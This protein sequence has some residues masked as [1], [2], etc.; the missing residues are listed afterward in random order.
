MHKSD[1]QR[2]N[3]FVSGCNASQLCCEPQEA[4]PKPPPQPVL[5]PIPPKNILY[6][7]Y[8]EVKDKKTQVITTNEVPN[9][10]YVVP[11]VQQ[12]AVSSKK[13]SRKF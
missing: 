4:F 10:V 8:V 12:T 7:V 3:Y 13:G 6:N 5:P 9:T 11:A 1:S 2:G